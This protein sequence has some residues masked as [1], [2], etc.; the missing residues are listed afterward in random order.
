MTDPQAAVALFR[1][2]PAT[3][4]AALDGVTETETSLVPAPGK[5]TIR[6]IVRHLADTEI[7]VGMRLRLIIAEGVNQPPTLTPFDQEAWAKHLAYQTSDPLDSFERFRSVRE[8]TGS[9]LE[10]QPAEVFDRIGIHP[11]R[12]A[13]TLLEW[14]NI[15]GAHVERHAEQILAIR[16]NA[17]R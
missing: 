7:V 3:L 8:D 2:G 13:K 12:G 4:K 6:Q 9:L 15:F 14:V 16:R 11:E 1:R 10:S 17:P 5:W